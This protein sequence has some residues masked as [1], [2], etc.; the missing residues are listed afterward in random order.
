[1]RRRIRRPSSWSSR[2]SATSATTVAAIASTIAASFKAVGLVENRVSMVADSDSPGGAGPVRSVNTPTIAGRRFGSA[3]PLRSSLPE[4]SVSPTNVANVPA[5]DEVISMRWHPSDVAGPAAPGGAETRTRGTLA[6]TTLR[7]IT[8]TRVAVTFTSIAFSAAS[9]P[10]SGAVPSTS[11]PL[12][13]IE[14][15]TSQGTVT[16]MVTGTCEISG[17]VTLLSWPFCGQFSVAVVCTTGSSGVSDRQ[18][19]AD[20]AGDRR[21]P[22]GNPHV[23]CRVAGRRRRHSHGHGSALIGP[24]RLHP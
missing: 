21:D 15:T 5:S 1:M 19:E 23:S 22:A 14:R 17:A 12:G 6:T 8:S 18:H 16:V 2:H 9:L 11:P 4:A 7:T 3:N 24:T 20:Q 10:S 13:G